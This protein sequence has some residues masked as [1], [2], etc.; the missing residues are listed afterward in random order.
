MTN[1]ERLEELE[2]RI[3]DV[4]GLPGGIG[5]MLKSIV[6]PQLK[7]VPESEAHKVREAVRHIV[8]TL[9]DVFDV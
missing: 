7:T 6:I 2:K 5:M 9:K 3:G 1:K 8:E 4:R